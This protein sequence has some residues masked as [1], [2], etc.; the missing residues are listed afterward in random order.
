MMAPSSEGVLVPL[1]VPCLTFRR[2]H[3]LRGVTRHMQIRKGAVL[4]VAV[5]RPGYAGKLVVVVAG[6]R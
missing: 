6:C 5:L 1:L 4:I 3:H 2:L